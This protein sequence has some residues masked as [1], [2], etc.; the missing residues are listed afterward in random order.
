MAAPP[1]VPSDEIQKKREWTCRADM[2]DSKGR[3]KRLA[4]QIG[5]E[6]GDVLTMTRD[7][8]FAGLS[9]VACGQADPFWRVSQVV[10]AVNRRLAGHAGSDAARSG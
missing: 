2:R 9:L 1:Y 3:L 6:P 10:E 5:V 7:G 8:D 4:W